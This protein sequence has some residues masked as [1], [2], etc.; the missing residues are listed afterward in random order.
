MF[1]V[2]WHKRNY[3]VFNCWFFLFFFWHYLLQYDQT[4]EVQAVD[5]APAVSKFCLVSLVDAHVQWRRFPIIRPPVIVVN[6]ILE[7]WSILTHRIACWVH[8]AHPYFNS[9]FLE[10]NWSSNRSREF[11]HISWIIYISW[12]IL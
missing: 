12:I 8:C 5:D 3:L 11:N 7:L 6:I 9:L 10:L 4:E 1:G 2:V